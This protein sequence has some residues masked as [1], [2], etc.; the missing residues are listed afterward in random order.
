MEQIH[1]YSFPFAAGSQYSYSPFQKVAPSWLTW[2]SLDYAGHGKRMFEPP[3][4]NIDEIVEE[5]KNYFAKNIKTPYVFYGHSMGSLIIYIL[6]LEFIKND[7]PLPMHI[8]L[9][10]RGGACIPERFR[11]AAYITKEEIVGE[12]EAMDGDVKVLLDNPKLFDVY[13][14]VLRADFMV[15]E[16]YDYKKY[17]GTK[18]DVPATVFIGEKDNYTV[19]QAQQWQQEFSQPIDLHILSGRHFFI[20]DHIEKMMKTITQTIENHCLEVPV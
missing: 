14:K 10:G 3:M 17:E 15:L 16:S 6:I 7:I 1:L 12:I 5:Y 9:S 19:K 20:F 2:Q 4:T 11:N 8:F 18:I 13:E